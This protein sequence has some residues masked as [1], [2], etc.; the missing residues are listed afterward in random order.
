MLSDQV[1]MMA[2]ELREVDTQLEAFAV[3]MSLCLHLLYVLQS[4]GEHTDERSPIGRGE[5]DFPD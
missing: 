2:F 4:V 1:R 3:T 5:S